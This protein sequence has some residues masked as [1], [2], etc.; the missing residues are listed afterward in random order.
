[1]PVLRHLR[2]RIS[3]L[4]PRNR[5]A[6]GAALLAASGSSTLAGAM[7]LAAGGLPATPSVLAYASPPAMGH[8]AFKAAPSPATATPVPVIVNQATVSPFETVAPGDTLSSIS[9]ARC[10]T[11]ADWTGIFYANK[12]L[13]DPDS[14][15][16]GTVLK[17]DC[18]SPAYT[19]PPQPKIVRTVQTASAPATTAPAAHPT[20][21]QQAPVAQGGVLTEAQIGVLWLNAGGPAW[22]EPQAERIAECESGGRTDAYNPS[23]ATGLWQILGQVVP[24]NLTDPAVNAANA[25]AK[26]DAG[27]GVTH[28]NFSAWVCQ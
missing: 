12:A 8:T 3:A 14:L 27:N 25:V 24:G 21:Q 5:L 7:L 20:V 15:P 17:I 6:S 16:V 1:M 2:S 9:V 23:G 10:G 13:H 4:K 19:P 11:A 22:A 18:S 26:F 28:D